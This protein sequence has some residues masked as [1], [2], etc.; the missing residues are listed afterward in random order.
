MQTNPQQAISTITKLHFA[1]SFVGWCKAIAIETLVNKWLDSD[2]LNA[3]EQEVKDIYMQGSGSLEQK[4]KLANV[5]LARLYNIIPEHAPFYDIKDGPW[6]VAKDGKH[7]ATVDEIV[8]KSLEE[9]HSSQTENI[10][11]LEH[12]IFTD[13]PFLK[14][15]FLTELYNE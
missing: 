13:Y 11:E 7:I 8:L 15:C 2:S 1:R 9:I 10:D 14:E 4:T 6:E 3:D 12:S 5:F